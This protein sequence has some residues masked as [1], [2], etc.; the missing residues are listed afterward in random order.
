MNETIGEKGGY[1]DRR[2]MMRIQQEQKDRLE[3]LEEESISE[4][5]KQVQKKQRFVLI[6]TIPIVLAGGVIQ[7]LLK[8]KNKKTSKSTNWVATEEK[9]E[10]EKPQTIS[11][12]L[13]DGRKKTISVV[14]PSILEDVPENIEI[15]AEVPEK[16]EDHQI[17]L[18][19]GYVR[20]SEF[21]IIS[22]E[23]Q[24]KIEDLKIQTMIRSYEDELKDIRYDLRRLLFDFHVLVEEEK[25]T[26][27]SAEAE[28]LLKELSDLIQRMEELERRIQIEDY[29]KYDN[30]YLY[31]LIEEYLHD[32]PDKKAI[33]T[34]KNTA[35]YESISRKIEDFHKQTET[36]QKKVEEEKEAFE[37]REKDFQKMKEEAYRFK[38]LNQEF[39]QFQTQ[40][41]R[42]LREVQEKVSNAVSVSEKVR[43]EAE[44]LSLQS[45]K[46]MRLLTL[47]MV[48]PG[49]RG[50]RHTALSTAAYLYFMNQLLQ[51]KMVSKK[52]KVIDVEDYRF[53]IESSI[54]E[55][56]KTSNYLLKTEHEIQKMM[57]K[58]K[59]DFQ[60]YFGVYP[61]CDELYHN[62]ENILNDIQEREYEI[63]KIKDQQELE[64]SKNEAKILTKGEYP[65]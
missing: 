28:K 21:G 29:Q 43:V 6:Q 12:T 27:K 1:Q 3:E 45:R 60:D 39:R 58:I 44:A 15:L 65:M 10:K 33:S 17:L 47:S 19:D 5:E 56:S 48:L 64:L 55:I 8:N 57:G 32:Y 20:D 9:E 11:V 40:Q 14:V 38:H 30:N 7:T 13:G 53:Q 16:V 52:Y 23:T 41:E 61:E 49:V 50:A 59:H 54:Q 24:E 63:Q 31:T 62:L 18:E 4:L 51:P 22:K 26:H 42:L 2:R 46:L 25:D 36:F 35:F 37:K 34:I